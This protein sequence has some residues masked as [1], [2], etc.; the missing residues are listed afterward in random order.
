MS[1]DLP[2]PSYNSEYRL[3]RRDCDDIRGDYEKKLFRLCCLAFG[4]GNWEKFRTIPGL[5]KYD[6]PCL[7]MTAHD[8]L[9]VF[10]LTNFWGLHVWPPNVKKETKY[11]SDRCRVIDPSLPWLD[12]YDHL[13][14]YFIDPL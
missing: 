5:E 6:W 8:E 14:E 4:V 10:D 13:S 11:M 9:G 2:L 7:E 3:K 12:G 1:S